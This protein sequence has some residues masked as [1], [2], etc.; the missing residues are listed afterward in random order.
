MRAA[1]LPFAACAYEKAEA[2]CFDSTLLILAVF[3]EMRLS[4]VIA[5]AVQLR[6]FTSFRLIGCSVK[7]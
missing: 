1:A 4:Y 3:A 6:S 2:D 5:S 7:L